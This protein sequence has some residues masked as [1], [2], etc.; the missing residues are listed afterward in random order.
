LPRPR[1]QAVHGTAP[2][3]PRSSKS[4]KVGSLGRWIQ[5]WPP[6][7]EQNRFGLI[8]KLTRWHQIINNELVNWRFVM[9]VYSEHP[10]TLDQIQ[11]SLLNK[12]GDPAKAKKP[13]YSLNRP[14]SSS[15]RLCFVS[16]ASSAIR[17]EVRQQ[18]VQIIAKTWRLNLNLEKFLL[19]TEF[20]DDK[21]CLWIESS[22]EST[23]RYFNFALRELAST[24]HPAFYSRILRAF[25]RLEDSDI[26][27]VERVSD[28]CSLGNLLQQMVSRSKDLV[29]RDPQH[30]RGGRVM[31]RHLRLPLR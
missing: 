1:I 30:P 28:S 29:L 13:S 16:Y 7:G 27:P 24:K 14:T 18:L 12:L 3:H 19:T 21:F 20:G 17:C 10:D 26:R 9:I 5:N 11:L 15:N 4:L 8:L 31:P 6:I 2:Q 23:H 25:R 22:P